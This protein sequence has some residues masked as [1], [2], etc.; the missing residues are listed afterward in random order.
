MKYQ[1]KTYCNWVGTEQY[2][3][4]EGDYDTAEEALEAFGGADAAYEQSLEDHRP[5]WEIVEAE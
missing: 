3:D 4:I 2:H 1:I 5:E